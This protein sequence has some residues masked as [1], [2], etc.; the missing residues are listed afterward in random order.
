MPEKEYTKKL[1]SFLAAIAWVDGQVRREE[2]EYISGIARKNVGDTDFEAELHMIFSD[3]QE[4]NDI[5]EY[6]THLKSASPRGDKEKT[7]QESIFNLFASDGIIPSSEGELTGLL[8]TVDEKNLKSLKNVIFYNFKNEV[9]NS[10]DG[11]DKPS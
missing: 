9:G 2:I 7:I 3:K 1:L 6:Y 5:L 8:R 4:K 11:E 10:G